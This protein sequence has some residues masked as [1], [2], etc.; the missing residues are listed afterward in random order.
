MVD[1]AAGLRLVEAMSVRLFALL[2]L[3]LGVL[4]AGQA[5]AAAGPCH[6]NA[7]IWGGQG[8]ANAE[9]AYGMEWAPFGATEWG[10]SLIHI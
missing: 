3:V 8:L 2:G 1:F 6:T 9:A 4:F 7:D 5:R 10:L